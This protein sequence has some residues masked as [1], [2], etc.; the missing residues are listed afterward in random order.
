M[1][2]LEEAQQLECVQL[3]PSHVQRHCGAGSPMRPIV[4]VG[5]LGPIGTWVLLDCGHW[6]EIRDYNIAPMLGRK[7]P[8]Q[9]RCGCCRLNYLPRPS[10]LVR[11]AELTT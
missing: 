9:A 5:R 4:G 7:R 2:T 11:V 8:V 3:R 10:D 6:R 1:L